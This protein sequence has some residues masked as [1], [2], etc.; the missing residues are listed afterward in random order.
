MNLEVETDN[1]ATVTATETVTETATVT[2]TTTQPIPLR[3]DLVQYALDFMDDEVQ[4]YDI[5]KSYTSEKDISLFICK[6]GLICAHAVYYSDGSLREVSRND[7]V[8]VSPFSPF[9]DWQ[10]GYDNSIYYSAIQDWYNH[11][12][13]ESTSVFNTVNNVFI[14]EDLVPLWKVLEVYKDEQEVKVEQPHVEED[15]EDTTMNTLCLLY[16][17]VSLLFASIVGVIVISTYEL[18]CV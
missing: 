7:T 15:D 8:H 11:Y 10:K 4:Y 1:E 2:E 16:T 9:E 6:S 18:L 12:N 14:G 3:Q 13:G 5:I 17:S